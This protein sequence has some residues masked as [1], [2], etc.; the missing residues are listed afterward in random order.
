MTAARLAEGGVLELSRRPPEI[1]LFGAN[2]SQEVE[3]LLAGPTAHVDADFGDQLQRGLR[4]DGCR[5]G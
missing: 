2:A 3:V 1:L 4:A 5:F